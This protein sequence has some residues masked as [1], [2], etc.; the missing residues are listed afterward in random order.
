[1]EVPVEKIIPSYPFVQY[2]D[3]PNIVAFFEAYNDM[4]QE[5][6]DELNSLNLPYWPSAS[7]SGKLLDWVVEGF[8]EKHGHCFRYLRMQSLRGLI[9][10][11][12]TTVFRMLE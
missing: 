6:L 9:T 3:D 7:L 10:P 1:M 2:R 11:L 8:T 4:A 12:I 5:Y